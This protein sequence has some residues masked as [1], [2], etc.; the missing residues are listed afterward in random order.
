MEHYFAMPITRENF[1]D[2]HVHDVVVVSLQKIVKSN[3]MKVRIQT[4]LE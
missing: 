2:F 3:E 1:I 4:L